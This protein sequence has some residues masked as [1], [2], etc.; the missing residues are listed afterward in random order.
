[1]RGSKS[2]QAR[3]VAARL[4]GK[5]DEMRVVPALIYALTDGDKMVK[6][7]ARDGLRFISRKFD[8]YGMPD[9]PTGSQTF[10]GQRKW[11]QWYLTMFPDHVF[12][13]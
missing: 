5:S 2:W 3:R 11:R 1:M 7:L 6:R 12:L 8:G 13:E 10:N 4:L 9:D